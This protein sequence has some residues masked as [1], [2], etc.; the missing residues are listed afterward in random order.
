MGRLAPSQQFRYFRVGAG[1][2]LGSAQE[3][4]EV[5]ELPLHELF[6]VHK[7]DSVV[8]NVIVP[9]GGPEK[10]LINNLVEPRPYTK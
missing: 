2:E 6:E 3:P 9:E 10:G 1:A 5:N 7:V 4:K 8:E